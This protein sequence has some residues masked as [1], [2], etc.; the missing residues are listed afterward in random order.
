MK[1]HR[2]VSEKRTY[3]TISDEF[4]SREFV[5][6]QEIEIPDDAPPALKQYLELKL[7]YELRVQVLSSFVIE[8]M[9]TQEDFNRQ[10]VPYHGLLDAARTSAF[11]DG[12]PSA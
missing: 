5:A 12:A 9:I 10:L 3:R 7:L 1:I 8:Q 11:P 2:S 6:G 4:V